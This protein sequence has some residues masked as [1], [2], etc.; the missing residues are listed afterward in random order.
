MLDDQLHKYFFFAGW[1]NE[2]R[3]PRLIAWDESWKFSL[4]SLFS[5]FEVSHSRRDGK[6]LLSSPFPFCN[7]IVH[8]IGKSHLVKIQ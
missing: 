3:A 8:L 6:V 1:W 5:N 4:M 2:T 7:L